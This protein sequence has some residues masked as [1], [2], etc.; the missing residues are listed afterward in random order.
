MGSF[1]PPVGNRLD[2]GMPVCQSPCGRKT[3]RRPVGKGQPVLPEQEQQEQ[4]GAAQT[5]AGAGSELEARFG[6]PSW[7]SGRENDESERASLSQIS[8]QKT[9]PEGASLSPIFPENTVVKGR[10][11]RGFFNKIQLLKGRHYRRLFQT[12]LVSRVL[13]HR[14]FCPK[15]FTTAT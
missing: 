2:G 8:S 10:H 4:V 12:I 11:Y 13:D 7:M 3:R 15:I 9:K 5:A 14:R 1:N 6:P